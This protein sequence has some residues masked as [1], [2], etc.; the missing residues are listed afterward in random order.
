MSALGRVRNGKYKEFTAGGK[1]YGEEAKIP[2]EFS[3]GT[4]ACRLIISN[5]NFQ[6]VCNF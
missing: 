3:A 6:L 1:E 2:G 4:Q 5:S